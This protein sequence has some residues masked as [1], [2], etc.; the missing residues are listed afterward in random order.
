KYFEN[1]ETTIRTK[2][3]DMRIISWNTRQI[4]SGGMYHEIAIGRD[5]TEQRKAEESLV[6]YM[7]EM[8]MRLKQPIG[9]ISTTLQESAQMVKDGLLTDAEMIT[10]LQGQARNAAQITDNIQEFQTAIVERNNAIPDAYRKFLE[11]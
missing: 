4:G 2:N 3:G 8:A 11:G 10:I 9:I 7:T 6:A 1:L 5:I